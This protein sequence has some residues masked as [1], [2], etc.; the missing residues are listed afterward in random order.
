MASVA[1]L[2]GVIAVPLLG[3]GAGVGAYAL[4]D[5]TLNQV[6]G[7]LDGFRLH[8]ATRAGRNLRENC[9]RRGRERRAG[10]AREA[11]EAARRGG[12]GGSGGR[13]VGAV[14][15]LFCLRALRRA[16]AP[17]PAGQARSR[18][19]AC[20][21]LHLRRSASSALA[22]R[23][24][25]ATASPPRRGPRRRGPYNAQAPHRPSETAPRRLR[26]R[27]PGGSRWERGSRRSLAGT[28][29]AR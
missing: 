28:S 2:A 5:A 11:A 24:R 15:G 6:G 23:Q 8:A 17:Q 3:T 21:R 19:I 4:F 7:S 16:C 18:K 12:L 10:A 22:R 20:N 26:P 13:A 27:W 14:S 25:S 29:P 1:G 9:G